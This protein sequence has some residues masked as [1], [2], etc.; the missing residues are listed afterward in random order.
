[1]GEYYN[2]K[3][4]KKLRRNLRN[5]GT[6]A[7]A[8]LWTMIKKSQLEGRKFRRQFSIENYVVDFYCVSEKLAIELDGQEHFTVQGNRNDLERSKVI[9]KYGIR[10]LRYE[11]KLIYNSLESVLEDIKSNFNE[12]G[13]VQETN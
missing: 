7:E 11:N 5:E 1:M 10:I 3:P 13:I 8:V 12:T 9:E 2:R 6:P 4:L